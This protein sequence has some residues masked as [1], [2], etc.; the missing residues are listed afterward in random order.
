M[1]RLQEIARDADIAILIIH[2][3]RKRS[4]FD[5]TKIN[6]ERIRGS[7]VISQVPR[8]VWAIER[9]SAIEPETNRL[10]Q[11]KNNMVRYPSPIGFQI[12][13]TGLT[14]M[15][16]PLEPK[17]ETNRDRVCDLLSA[18]LAD[19]PMSARQMREEVQGAG[20]GSSTLWRAKQA[21]GIV[22]KR[23]EGHWTWAL[24]TLKI[25]SQAD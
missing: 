24:P 6:I 16:A 22:S 5:G 11:I 4:V 10:Q 13:D 14:W 18:L 9:P 25:G 12:T 8:S 2:H 1:I 20:F 7:S 17:L 19:G 3:L 21:L 15:D 23:Q